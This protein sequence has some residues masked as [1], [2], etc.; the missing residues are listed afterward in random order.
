MTV[1]ALRYQTLNRVRIRLEIPAS[2]Q[3]EPILSRLTSKF[4]LV[5]NITRA[6]LGKDDNG[7]D[8]DL[9]IQG[10]PQ[11]INQGLVY[12]N[13]LNIRIVGKPN[14]IEDDWY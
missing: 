13:S 6:R 8:C 7:N 12:L 11:Q 1:S 4:N 9:E 3:Q 14:A 2:Y 10:T 5:V